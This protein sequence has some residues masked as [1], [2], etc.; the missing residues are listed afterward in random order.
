M[1]PHYFHGLSYFMKKLTSWELRKSNLWYS[2]IW[3]WVW[4]LLSRAEAALAQTPLV[5][6]CQPVPFLWQSPMGI[7]DIPD[8]FIDCGVLNFLQWRITLIYFLFIPIN[9]LWLLSLYFSAVTLSLHP[10]LLVL[11]HLCTIR[12]GIVVPRPWRHG[13]SVLL[14]HDGAWT[15]PCHLLG[16]S[17]SSCSFDVRALCTLWIGWRPDTCTVIMS[18][19]PHEEC[20]AV[21][22]W[23]EFSLH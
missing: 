1:W 5:S 21:A 18:S 19:S 22:P 14:F 23:T 4:D 6:P 9:Y 7:N 13:V 10:F 12:N 8:C 15:L 16:Y 17:S 2:E 3:N 20:C 11:S